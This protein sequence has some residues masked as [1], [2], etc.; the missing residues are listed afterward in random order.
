MRYTESNKL[1]T[2]NISI[3]SVTGEFILEVDPSD[4]IAQ[5]KQKIQE[6][7]FS[8]ALDQIQL[9]H[10]EKIL[11]DEKTILD[12]GIQREE[13]L[14]LFLKL[15]NQIL[16]KTST[17]QTLNIEVDH[18][19][20]IEH[21]KKLI[22]KLNG[23]PT[24]KQRLKLDG[25]K[26]EDNLSLNHYSIDRDSK[27]TMVVKEHTSPMTIRV[28]N[29]SQTFFFEVHPTDTVM[30]IKKKISA[31]QGVETDI[32]RIVYKGKELADNATMAD[33]DIQ[34]D[35][36]LWLLLDLNKVPTY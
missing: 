20:T 10:G 16:I 19:N 3:R 26:I 33:H 9:L 2:M 18:N 28:K 23:T 14:N 31:H 21:V 11:E 29:Y 15:S 12:Y 5:V 36:C 6:K 8:V 34:H 27:I 35:T 7:R 24:E 30:S 17:G 22:E 25:K 1:R 32:Q 13:Q 4:T